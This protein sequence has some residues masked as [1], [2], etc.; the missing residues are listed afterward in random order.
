MTGSRVFAAS[1]ALATA[2]PAVWSSTPT[3]RSS[4]SNLASIWSNR[5][6]WDTKCSSPAERR[7]SIRLTES[8]SEPPL[9]GKTW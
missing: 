7:R 3:S 8:S 5:S 2:A 6:S 1:A 9:F 4:R